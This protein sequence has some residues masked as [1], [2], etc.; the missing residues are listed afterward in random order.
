VGIKVKIDNIQPAFNNAH[1]VMWEKHSGGRI[2]SYRESTILP[3]K[4]WKQEYNVKIITGYKQ[5]SFGREH[6]D[7]WLEAEFPNEEYLTWFMLRWS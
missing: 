7:A 1:R 3:A 5:D 6:Q 4:W 2:L